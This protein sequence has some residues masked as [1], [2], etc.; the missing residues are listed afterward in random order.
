MIKKYH[1]TQAAELASLA[2]FRAFVQASCAAHGVDEDVVWALQLAVDE[3]AANVIQHGYEGLNPGS[4][5]LELRISP[6]QVN[7]RLTDYG[8][9]FEPDSAPAPDV[10]APLEARAPGGFGL[11][12]IYSTMDA[13]DYTTSEEGNILSLTKTL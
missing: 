5:S 2:V 4:I 13:V 11:F 12:F 1:L 7:V 8:H 6:R 10:D 9:P 3:A